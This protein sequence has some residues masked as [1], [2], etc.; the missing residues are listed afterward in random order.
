[1]IQITDA[2]IQHSKHI[3]IGAAPA[4]TLSFIW[5]QSSMTSPPSDPSRQAER[6]RDL[7]VVQRSS[8]ARRRLTSARLVGNSSPET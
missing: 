5:T 1:L 2:I 4:A 7:A 3:V 6:R 8:Q